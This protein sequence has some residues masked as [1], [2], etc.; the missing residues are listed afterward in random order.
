MQALREVCPGNVSRRYAKKERD[1]GLWL[2]GS[3]DLLENTETY[4]VLNLFPNSLQIDSLDGIPIFQPTVIE[5]EEFNANRPVDAPRTKP[6]RAVSLL[7]PGPAQC[8]S[9]Q[10]RI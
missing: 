1:L 6:T 5:L 8:C 9:G 10:N 7:A 3:K 4:N 2:R